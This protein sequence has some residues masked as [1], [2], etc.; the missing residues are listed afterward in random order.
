MD[1]SVPELRKVRDGANPEDNFYTFWPDQTHRDDLDILIAGCGSN[2]AARYAF[3]HPRS[4]VVG[5]DLSTASLAHEA[6]LKDK[7][8]LAN[9]TLHHMRLEEVASLGRDFDFIESSG[10]LHHLPDPVL[11]LK[12]LGDVLR[13]DG[14]IAVM[15]YG[16]YGRTG[17]YMLQEMFRLL[18]LGQSE[19][20]VATVKQTLAAL[21]KRH[22]IHDYA[23]RSRDL[24]YDAGVVDTFLHHQDRAYTVTECLD[25][26]RQAGMSFMGWWDNILYYPESQFPMNHPL[27]AKLNALPE[28]SIW[29]FME[30]YNG[31]LGQHS[32]C[33]CR[34]DRPERNYKIDFGSEAFLDYIPVL[35]CRIVVPKDDTAKGTIAV[36]RDHWPAY[37]LNAVTSA[38]VQEIDG[39]KSIRECFACI[40]HP[41]TGDQAA[42]SV[43]KAAFEPLWRLSYIFLR[44]PS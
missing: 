38:L 2:A 31:T 36:Q 21:P 35:R 22:V 14:T 8:Q 30:L 39:K 12:A 37:T 20:D 26:V 25:F 33:V 11:G 28:E 24:Q 27:Y 44:I 43:C 32:F 6:Y 41:I 34:R 5:I 18:G 40:K 13:C 42:R 3:H 19:D 10:V 9:L 4:R 16:Q 29:Q 23:K 7:H 15:V 1:L 17:V